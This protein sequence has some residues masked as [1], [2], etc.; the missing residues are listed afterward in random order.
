MIKKIIIVGFAFLLSC[1]T[2]SREEWLSGNVILK[3]MINHEIIALFAV[4][5]TV[6]LASVAN[7]HLSLNRI[8][9]GK[10]QG[11][12]ELKEKA[13]EV[14]K[15]LKENS[16]YIFYGF[17]LTFLAIIFKG[18]NIDNNFI[19]ASVHAFCLWM[20]MLYGICLLDIYKVVF[21]L[22]DLELEIGLAEESS[23]DMPE[24]TPSK[25]E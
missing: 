24:G 11:N 12:Q 22:V 8:V 16:W 15:H 7:I 19:V 23:P 20:L 5:V 13:K 17:G 6:T 10:F 4:V 3:D 14:M 25:S 21:G 18:A 2:V 1:I 9:L